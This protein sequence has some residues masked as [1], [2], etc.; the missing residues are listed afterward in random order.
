MITT[1]NLYRK[2]RQLINETDDAASVTM[3]SEDTRSLD[4]HIAAL[5]PDAVLFI[6]KNKGWGNVNPK[7][8]FISSEEIIQNEDGT[9]IMLLPDDFV[10]L[11]VLEMEG[12]QRPCTSLYPATSAMAAA[13]YNP[14]TRAGFCKPVC[15]E[16]V[17][18]NGKRALCYYS[19]PPDTTPVVK[20][21]IYEACYNPMNGLSGDDVALHNAVAYQ[22]AAFLFGMF[23]RGNNAEYFSKIAAALCYNNV[24]TIKNK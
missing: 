17:S 15:V 19:L 16:H 8:L 12:W 9:G 10:A 14:H 18:V 4:E 3:L 20:K 6:Q 1:E 23:E 5:M 22:C 13:Q 21:F 11:T 7:S 24:E 2:V